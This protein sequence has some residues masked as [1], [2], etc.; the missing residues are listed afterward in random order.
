MPMSVDEEIAGL[1]LHCQ[2]A[3]ARIRHLYP[4]YDL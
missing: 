1:C 2:R 4:D 3:N